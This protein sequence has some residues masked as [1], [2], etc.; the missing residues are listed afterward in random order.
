MLRQFIL[1]AWAVAL[2]GGG[3]SAA[4]L[5]EDA[6]A[7]GT[8]EQVQA[9]A[10]SPNG[11]KVVMLSAGRG[12][13][14]TV[15]VGDLASGKIT[16]VAMSGGRDESLYWCNF[17]SNDRLICSFGGAQRYFASMVSFSR[18]VT[19]KT[20][21]TGFASLGQKASEHDAS[22]R[23]FD[24]DV[25][26]W[27]PGQRDTVLV[28]RA[29]IPE[30][31]MTGSMLGRTKTGLG[32]DRINL[33]TLK[34]VPVEPARRT[35]DGYLSDGHGH[36]R[37]YS[38]PVLAQVSGVVD[39]NRKLLS[40]T[41]EILTGEVR[42][43]YRKSGSRVW[44]DLGSFNTITREG[45]FPLAIEAETDSL[46]VLRKL[47]GR[48][49]LYRMALNG[50]GDLTLVAKDD[51]V[52]IDNVVRLGRGQRVIGYT[53]A[54]DRRRTV[55]FD[56]EFADLQR[57]LA[58]VLPNQPLIDFLGASADGRKVLV[59]AS[60]DTSPGD[61]YRYDRVSHKLEQ[62][63]TVRPELAGR[64][65][66][67]VQSIRISAPDGAQI[68]A[69]LT[70]P[71]GSSG[72]NLPAVVLPHGGPSARDEWGFDWLAQFLAARGYA[73]IQPNYRGSAGYGQQWE[74]QNGFRGWKRSI[75]DVTAAARYLVQQGIAD[76]NR[77]AI[78]GWSYG[79]YAALQSTVVEPGLYKAAVAVAPVTD[80]SLFRR[81]AA[82]FTNERLVDAFI[83]D[84][85]HLIEGSPIR[86]IA[87]INVPILLVHGEK[88][89]D[90]S[91]AHSERMYGE[92]RA[93]GKSAELIKLDGLDHAIADS[94]ARVRT[95]TRIGEFLESAI[96]R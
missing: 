41:T 82:F 70:L 4:S 64:K 3:A 84:G 67:H 25:I 37:V 48:N 62:V 59:H 22:L 39:V 76:P 63:A 34:A 44:E 11:E 26:D 20:D 8:R 10:I 77:L 57:S 68:P 61:F 49:A 73:V 32:V 33:N 28:S 12:S 66:A 7:F 92:L 53:Y 75:G 51:A 14:T 27:L 9:M 29:Y 88:D 42:Y 45:I 21:G 43:K 85:P 65:L 60:A 90:V 54:D 81:E 74:S 13:E 94:G 40:S 38:T 47:D 71:V 56:P 52:D 30:V 78:M 5:A 18:L 83:G 19:I 15:E 72:R 79:G 93:A 89:A 31:Y 35:I 23:Q 91:I 6:R 36:V 2:S 80:L 58:R 69:Y 24:G 1:G 17:A 95:L 46:F 50:T 96:G 55:Y 86:N 16:K 87:S